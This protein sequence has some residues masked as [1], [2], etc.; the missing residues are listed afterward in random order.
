MCLFLNNL[1][2]IKQVFRSSLK[3]VLKNDPS[4]DS[5]GRDES[6]RWSILARLIL[7][8]S[9]TPPP[10]SSSQSTN[11]SHPWLSS[12]STPLNPS[13]SSTQPTLQHHTSHSPASPHHDHRINCSI[14]HWQHDCH[15]ISPGER[16]PAQRWSRAYHSPEYWV[17]YRAYNE[18]CC[19][20]KYSDGHLSLFYNTLLALYPGLS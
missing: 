8:L 16:E 18:K 10:Y 19:H 9:P 6:N 14:E 2:I 15:S 7:L 11:G 13:W 20:T 12:S 5:T 1:W 17:C 3:R 4:H